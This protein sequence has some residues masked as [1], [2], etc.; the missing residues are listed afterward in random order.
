MTFTPQPQIQINKNSQDEFL[1][2]SSIQASE[3]IKLFYSLQD[4]QYSP[5]CE[6][7]L[8]VVQDSAS[9]TYKVQKVSATPLRTSTKGSAQCNYK[10]DNFDLYTGNSKITFALIETNH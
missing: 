7:I 3:S 8:Q 5:A 10:I 4:N 2:T 6:L 9:K 1:A